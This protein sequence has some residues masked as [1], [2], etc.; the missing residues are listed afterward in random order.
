MGIGESGNNNSR[1]NGA[2][3]SEGWED[4][5]LS[6]SRKRLSSGEL[7]F[8]LCDFGNESGEHDPGG[9]RMGDETREQAGC[10]HTRLTGNKGPTGTR[11]SVLT[12]NKES[13]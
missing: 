9:Y 3:N 2:G 6:G 12:G 10:I 11:W 4:G 7:C 13:Y 8:R 5:F 1:V